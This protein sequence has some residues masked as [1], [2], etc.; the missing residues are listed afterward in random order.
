MCKG[1]LLLL[2][3]PLLLLH[4]RVVVA[5]RET[6]QASGRHHSHANA[7]H[8]LRRAE[9][10]RPRGYRRGTVQSVVVAHSHHVSW[11]LLLLASRLVIGAL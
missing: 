8:R 5:V 7:A 10:G 4:V 6:R 11:L 1:A 9:L 3:L 2:L